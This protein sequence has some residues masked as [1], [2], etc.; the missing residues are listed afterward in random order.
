MSNN[1]NRNISRRRFIAASTG[2]FAGSALL[3]AMP[4]YSFSGQELKDELSE[5]EL[6]LVEQSSMAKEMKD[7]FHEG[8]SCAE[9][10]LMVSLRYLKKPEE[11]VWAAAG[12]GGGLGHKDLCGFLTAGVMGIGFASGSLKKEREEAKDWC[13]KKVKEYWKWWKGNAPLHCA[14][15]RT[16]GSSSKRCDR[17]GQLGAAKVEELICPVQA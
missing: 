17:L 3:K 2:L 10:L 1:V 4:S 6:K 16:P 5:E 14:D 8:Y 9:S 7:Y 12:Y 15:I 11:L 13:S